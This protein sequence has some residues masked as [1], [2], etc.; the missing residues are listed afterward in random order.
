MFFDNDHSI[1]WSISHPLS[2][3]ASTINTSA[4]K[5]NS[6]ILGNESIGYVTKEGSY[7][8][9]E[10]STKIAYILGIHPRESRSPNATWPL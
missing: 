4:A 10:S 7:G 9:L 6:K 3:N 5:V 2:S 8:N 1:K